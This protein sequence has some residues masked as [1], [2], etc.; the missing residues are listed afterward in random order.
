KFEFNVVDYQAPTAD[1]IR[2]GSFTIKF[3]STITNSLLNTTF[4]DS[5][6][7]PSTIVTTSTD[8]YTIRFDSLS[9]GALSYYMYDTVDGQDYVNK[10]CFGDFDLNIV[11]TGLQVS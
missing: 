9:E 10:F 1:T 8:D 4:Y 3:D 7:M 5:E 2:D 6:G 11:D